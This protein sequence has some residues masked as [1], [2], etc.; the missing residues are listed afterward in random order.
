MLDPY[1]S[2]VT[3]SGRPEAEFIKSFLNA[4]GID[5]ELSQEAAGSVFGLSVGT[6]GAVEIFVP[7]SKAGKARR[8]LA[9][10]Q[11]RK[12]GGGDPD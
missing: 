11:A 3:V 4:E 2:L 7:T 6:L 1:V 8:M 10:Y 9:E 12:E 5:C